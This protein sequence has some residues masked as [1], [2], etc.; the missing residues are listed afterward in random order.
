MQ[1]GTTWCDSDNYI[2]RRFGIEG[3]DYKYDENGQY[4][5]IVGRTPRRTP[6][7]ISASSCSITS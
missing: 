1:L 3:T 7:R 6:L 2:A 5:A 4:V